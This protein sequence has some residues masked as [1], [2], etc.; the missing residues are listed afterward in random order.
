MGKLPGAIR[1]KQDPA[2]P[3]EPGLKFQKGMG[4]LRFV[5][6]D[7]KSPWRITQCFL[8][9]EIQQSHEHKG[10]QLQ[11]FSTSSASFH[12]SSMSSPSFCRSSYSGQG[13]CTGILI[14]YEGLWLLIVNTAF[15]TW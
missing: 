3:K 15:S 10:Y 7:W 2:N 8:L 13:L 1:L 14:S 5:G 12:E 4:G 6:R 11:A 9:G